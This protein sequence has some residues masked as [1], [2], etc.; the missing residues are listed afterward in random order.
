MVLVPV[1]VRNPVLMVMVRSGLEGWWLMMMMAGRGRW[2]RGGDE[3]GDG[4]GDGVA[5]V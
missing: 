3:D 5:Y 4:D 2:R 1:P